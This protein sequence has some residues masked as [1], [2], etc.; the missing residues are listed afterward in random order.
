DEALDAVVAN[1]LRSLGDTMDM[2]HGFLES[3][4]VSSTSLSRMVHAARSGGAHGAKITGA[5]GRGS[6]VALAPSDSGSDS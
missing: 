1:E 4:G 3:L 2:N 5:G 6:V